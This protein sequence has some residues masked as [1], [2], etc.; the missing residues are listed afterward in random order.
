MKTTIA[1]LSDVHLAPIT[2]FGL[3]HVN[4][5]RG[6]GLANWLLKR[7]K[8]H[9]RS[10]VDRLTADLARQPVDHV[11]VSGDLTNLGLPGE[12]AAALD[13]LTALGSPG[14]VTVV[15]GNHDVYCRLWSDPGI[16]RWRPYMTSDA[17]GA[18]YAEPVER[19]FPFVRLIGGVALV[20]LISAVPTRPFY[21]SGRLGEPQLEALV[22]VLDRLARDGLVRVVVVHHPP[23]PGQADARRGLIDAERLE[24]VLEA[25]GAELVL[26]GHNHV[27]MLAA[28]RWSGGPVY[29]VGVAS[30]SIGRGYKAEPLGRYNLIHIDR[31]GPVAAFDI[32][33][34]GIQQP[35][36]PVVEVGHRRLQ[37]EA[38]VAARP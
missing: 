11:I 38:G 27:E 14:S 28:R 22:G 12:F 1:H 19:G 10:V 30:A 4:V 32:H 16:E 5:K 8:V 15:P 34:R 18:A 3:A 29:T 25:H 23:L 9:L 7:R 21:A 24:R 37:V 17:A 20:G 36:G 26:H 31:S 33:T 2:G 6:L 13:W 35:D